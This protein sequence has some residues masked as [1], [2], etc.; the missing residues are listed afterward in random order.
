MVRHFPV[1]LQLKVLHKV[2]R[3]AALRS[4]RWI[5]NFRWSILGLLSA[6]NLGKSVKACLT[7]ENCEDWLFWRVG[8]KL[9]TLLY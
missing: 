7:V 8:C 3:A 1:R 2:L 4:V 6:S 9:Y 5:R